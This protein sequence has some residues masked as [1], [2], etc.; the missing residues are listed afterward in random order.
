M[1]I[2]LASCS[3]EGRIDQID[4]SDYIPEQITVTSVK[5]VPGGAVIKYDLPDDDNLRYVKV[6]YERNG[7]L[8]EN[9]SS[10]YVDSL[11]IMGFGDSQ[12]HDAR[13][14]SIGYN[15]R[16]SM[17][18]EIKISPLE[19]VVRTVVLSLDAVF[20]G[21]SVD[22]KGNTDN[23]QLAIVLMRDFNLEDNG[24]PASEIVW[25]EIY[26]FHATGQE[27]SLKRRDLECDPALFGAY[28]RD[29]WGNCS[30]TVY[31]RLTPLEEKELDKSSWKRAGFLNDDY[32]CF[33]SSDAMYGFEHLWNG[34]TDRTSGAFFTITGGR[35][36][37]FTI[38]LGYEA[39]LS[40]MRIY[41][42]DGDTFTSWIPWHWQVYGCDNPSRSGDMDEW[43][44]LG[45]FI[46]YKPSGM[47]EDGTPG[48]WTT[49]DVYHLLNTND[50]DFVSSEAVQDAQRPTRYVRFRLIDNMKSAFMEYDAEPTDLYY[51]FGEITLWGVENK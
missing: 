36:R 1:L 45:D 44:L 19:P 49:E 48:S 38:D 3:E 10:R 33:G 37:I 25:S 32:S 35:E 23:S 14:F 11:V 8:C 4:S 30:D 34:A 43:F 27:V 39:K 24:K 50:Y 31:T 12:E 6:E 29:R 51:G 7:E 15:D 18:I 22:M 16:R 2:A 47:A 17:P 46:Q 42:R 20:G 26:T 9:S 40:R 28:V 13:I 5:S 41:P 21:V